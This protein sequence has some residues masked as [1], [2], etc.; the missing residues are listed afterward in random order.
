MSVCVITPAGKRQGNGVRN[1]VIL[2]QLDQ[3]VLGTHGVRD[4]SRITE[5]RKWVLMYPGWNNARR[6]TSLLNLNICF[7]VLISNVDRVVKLVVET[8]PD[9]WIPVG[10][11]LKLRNITVGQI[12][13]ISSA[14]LLDRRRGVLVGN[15]LLQIKK[16]V[17]TVRGIRGSRTICRGRQGILG[18]GTG[19]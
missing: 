8:R 12:S 1:L 2:P 4:E 5:T 14:F 19:F 6:A 18:G 7:D 9:P 17:K 13:L 10:A 3:G 15:Y 11:T 16:E